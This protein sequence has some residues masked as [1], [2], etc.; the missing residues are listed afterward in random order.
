[1]PKKPEKKSVKH[2]HPGPGVD[3]AEC[4]MGAATYTPCRQPA[5][6]V[7]MGTDK[8]CLPMCGLCADHNVS[9]RGARYVQQGEEVQIITADQVLA[10]FKN[11]MP[12]EVEAD[13][14]TGPSEAQ[15][16]NLAALVSR[17]L[18]LQEILIPE[19]EA[20]L[21]K[22]Q[23]ELK[24]LTEITLPNVMTDARVS[25]WVY[26]DRND[27]EWETDLV[28]DVKF[29]VK[30]EN[31][32]GFIGWLEKK[33]DDAIVKRTIVIKFGRDQVKAAKKF[34]ADLAKRKVDLEPEVK[35]EIHYQTLQSYCR[36][37]R[38]KLIKAGRNPDEALP[39][40]VDQF[41]LRFAV[42]S[43]KE[44]KKGVAAFDG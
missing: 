19:A 34:L 29:S 37:E 3:C 26:K 8:V 16:K 27:G 9:N 42:F 31:L 38:E 15:V 30:K 22:L 21:A 28:E 44:R 32:P 43:K 25:G 5:T 1:M 36:E 4:V 41:K 35:E 7:V 12:L 13:E 20:E 11:P 6:F 33:K 18:K 24:E 23:K 14:E 40:Q 10:S 39:K 17:G 2:M